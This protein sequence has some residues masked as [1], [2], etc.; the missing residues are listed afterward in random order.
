MIKSGVEITN[1]LKYLN[2]ELNSN[3]SAFQAECAYTFYHLNLTINREIFIH[4]YC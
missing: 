3:K 1:L 4:P 2:T